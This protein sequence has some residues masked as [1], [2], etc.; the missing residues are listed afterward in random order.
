MSIG[1]SLS[2]LFFLFRAY[3][4]TCVAFT[5]LISFAL[6]YLF[7]YYSANVTYP[8]FKSCVVSPP[9]WDRDRS[10][11]GNPNRHDSPVDF[12]GFFVVCFEVS[13]PPLSSG[14]GFFGV[15]RAHAHCP[16]MCNSVRIL[17]AR[18][19]ILLSRLQSL[20]VF[21]RVNSPYPF[22][23]DILRPLHI[24]W[25]LFFIVFLANVLYRRVDI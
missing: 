21:T 25:V 11:P 14:S 18:F 16:A 10:F 3:P 24:I 5:R 7:F 2:D 12:L 17:P 20:F 19:P 23:N 9:P 1:L 13:P 8:Y 6:L 4:P 15:C 22:L